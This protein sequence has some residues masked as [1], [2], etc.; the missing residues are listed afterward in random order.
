MTH[1]E[2]RQLLFQ[3]EGL[4]LDFKREYQVNKKAPD[5]F[6]GEEWSKLRDGQR[7]ELI[8]DIL[9]LTNGNVGTANQPAHLIVGAEDDKHRQPDGT[10]PLFDVSHLELETTSLISLVNGACHPPLPD[11]QC[12][13]IQIDGTT[14]IAITIPPSLQVHS[15]IRVLTPRSRSF[16]AFTGGARVRQKPEIPRGIFLLR[17]HEGTYWGSQV[18]VQALSGEKSPLPVVV[19]PELIRLADYVLP[20]EERELVESTFIPPPANHRLQE[21]LGTKGKLWIVGPP[22]RW[23]SHLATW[24]AL[25]QRPPRDIYSFPKAVDWEQLAVSGIRDSVIIFPDAVGFNEYDTNKVDTE[26]RPLNKLRLDGNLI[27]ATSSDSVFS[28]AENETRLG[29]WVLQEERFYLNSNSYDYRTK[30]E[31]LKRLL[32]YAFAKGTIN[33]RQKEWTLSL[34]TKRDEHGPKKD[35]DQRVWVRSQAEKLLKEVWF[36]GTIE[37]FIFESL[38]KATHEGSVFDQLRNYANAEVRIQSWFLGLEESVRCLLLTLSIFSGSKDNQLWARHRNIV[39]R[40]RRLNS[41]LDLLPLGI[42]RQLAR[43]YV[44]ADGPI[45]IDPAVFQ[46]VRSEL[47]RNYREYFVEI[48]DLLREWSIPEAL[49]ATDTKE[50]EL[51]IRDSENVRNAIARMI[52]EVGKVD[53]ES[54]SDLL[55]SWAGH[56]VGRIRK[57]AGIA[58]REV[59]KQPASAQFALALLEDWA[60]DTS[61]A[62][63]D[64]LRWAA[65]AALGRIASIDYEAGVS[66]QALITLQRLGGDSSERVVAAVAQSFR[67]MGAGLPV[68]RLGG[69]LTQLAKQKKFTRHEVARA[70]DEAAYKNSGEVYKLLDIWAASQSSNVQKTAVFLLCTARRIPTKDKRDILAK[71]FDRNG[72]LFETLREVLEDD[73]EQNKQ[74]ARRVIADIVVHSAQLSQRL[75]ASFAKQYEKDSDSGQVLLEALCPND[76]PGLFEMQASVHAV[77][78]KLAVEILLSRPSV[79]RAVYLVKLLREGHGDALVSEAL[80]TGTNEGFNWWF[81]DRANIGTS[82]QAIP[83]NRSVMEVGKELGLINKRL[84]EGK[85]RQISFLI[86]QIEELRQ[87]A[88]HIGSYDFS[89]L[90]KDLTDV[91]ILC[92]SDQYRD[93]LKAETVARAVFSRELLVSETELE[94]KIQQKSHVRT[95]L[96]TEKASALLTESDLKEKARVSRWFIAAGAILPTLLV[97]ILS[98]YLLVYPTRYLTLN[99]PMEVSG[100]THVSGSAFEIV[101]EVDHDMCILVTDTTECYLKESLLQF[102]EV[103]ES[104]T[105][106]TILSIPLIILC[107]IIFWIALSAALIRVYYGS[108]KVQ[109]KH[110]LDGKI[111]QVQ[112]D[113]ERLSLLKD[114]ISALAAS[115]SF[116]ELAELPRPAIARA[117]GQPNH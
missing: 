34:L 33:E 115:S 19:R 50:E 111:G 62:N 57:T 52:G 55:T 82:G 104:Y 63:A 54:V 77:H 112:S 93:Y 60:S 7:D 68:Q 53:L 32:Q 84:C 79:E 98:F 70:L 85:Q 29:E 56:P 46:M 31:I 92:R 14:L 21:I 102:G 16:D 42:L 83:L 28:D 27:I 106:S 22:D 41:H 95:R 18:E 5:G 9:A 86:K 72:L 1:D 49:A 48:L 76:D 75:T 12:E 71:F 88:S 11:L 97:G 96:N 13:K 67:M 99:R 43:P 87:I 105:I 30:I 78:P 23:T 80:S 108:I 44:T 17:S 15:T 110:R 40:L 39:E 47:A 6:S 58:L 74:T 45:I 113:I 8:K 90:D 100:D 101:K 64:N 3:N 107:L 91:Q 4:K 66:R 116:I 61:S 69:V 103:T 94:R 114:R 38:P 36:P 2:L 109:E 81:A 117:A 24:V 37:S 73:N 20:T 51:L 35:S 89:A 65:A 10:R 25:Q 59:A 26:L